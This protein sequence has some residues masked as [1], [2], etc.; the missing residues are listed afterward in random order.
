MSKV[1]QHCGRLP[2]FDLLSGASSVSKGLGKEGTE[3]AVRNDVMDLCMYASDVYW[4]TLAL[5]GT[6]GQLKQKPMA[7]SVQLRM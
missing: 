6:P 3:K 1:E 2:S 4:P 5:Q 7:N